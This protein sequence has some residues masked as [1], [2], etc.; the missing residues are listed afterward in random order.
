VQADRAVWGLG[1]CTRDVSLGALC[2]G[3]L[4]LHLPGI[5]MVSL[6]LLRN[7]FDLHEC[8]PV[9]SLM[10]I[11][12]EVTFAKGGGQVVF[13]ASQLRAF[14]PESPLGDFPALWSPRATGPAQQLTGQSS[15]AQ[16]VLGS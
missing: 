2:F 9:R 1:A 3:Q 5:P 14:L 8:V 16:A 12:R 11:A 13:C 7:L 6:P 4:V 15:N 10:R